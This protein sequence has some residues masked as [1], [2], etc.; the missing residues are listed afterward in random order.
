MKSP[1]AC[2]NSPATIG[3]CRQSRWYPDL[4]AGLRLEAINPSGCSDEATAA[5][6]GPCILE[7]AQL[8]CCHSIQCQERPSLPRRH[9]VLRGTILSFTTGAAGNCGFM[10]FRHI[11]SAR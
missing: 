5:F 1:M 10:V 11:G 7:L 6:S 2:H 3:H 9:F 4:R 8:E